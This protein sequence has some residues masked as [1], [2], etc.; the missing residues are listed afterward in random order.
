MIRRA[1]RVAL[2]TPALFALFLVVLDDR[3]AASFATFGSFALLAMVDFGGPLRRRFRGYVVVTAV[4]ALLVAAGTALSHTVLGAAVGMAVVATG[5]SALA[6]LGGYYAA[7]VPALVLPFL[8]A[9][10]APAPAGSS[11]SRLLG[12]CVAGLVAAAAA[13]VLWPVQ[14][15]R[16]LAEAMATALDDVAAL[17]DGAAVDEA[18]V[19]RLDAAA[20]NAVEDATEQFWTSSLRPSGPSAHDRAFVLLLGE[21]RWI[22]ELTRLVLGNRSRAS[23]DDG[24]LTVCTGS[25]RASA[26]A[27]RG[28]PPADLAA[29]EDHRAADLAEVTRSSMHDLAR[30]V[31]PVEVVAQL[32]RSFGVRV[33]S[34]AVLAVAA[35]V[36]LA[37][38]AVVDRPRPSVVPPAPAIGWTGSAQRLHVVLASQLR[39]DGV[40]LRSALR[41]GVALGVA[42]AV[43][44]AGDLPNSFWVGLGAL[45][46][47][48]SNALGTGYTVLQ[49]LAGT[50]LGFALA[51]GLVH[52]A[53]SRW[54]L[55]AL[56][57]VT[58]F[59]AA[60]TPTAVHFLV[61]QASFTVLVV[62]L[63]NLLEPVGWKVGL[64]R[65]QDVAIGLV[66]SLVAS[67]VLWPRG[68]S[69]ALVSSATTSLAA[70][71]RY[72]A[73]A[74]ARWLG[75]EVSLAG[76]RDAAMSGVLAARA[77]FGVY[78]GE[79]GRRRVA[80]EVAAA[81]VGT[82]S[83]AHL[84]AEAVDDIAAG[85]T[86]PPAC[87]DVADRL[88][89][90]AGDL[91]ACWAT[92][93]T[94]DP[95]LD[96]EHLEASAR[97]DQALLAACLARRAGDDVAT[98]RLA[99]VD[100]WLRLLWELARRTEDAAASASR[101][102][103]RPWWA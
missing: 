23:G 67:L 65:L 87:A 71:G 26:A 16:R 50:V 7:A 98:L 27:L 56:L 30:G 18:A 69:R 68:A 29:L 32:R 102:M 55:W 94:G 5:V 54:V 73:D 8:L 70:S 44:Q 35:N 85:A 93:G 88:I 34:Y 9:V 84:A 78:L 40:W 92:L 11:P 21:L 15:R 91:A 95:R 3:N 103:E 81:L 19:A 24:L 79:R 60:Y 89:S 6:V 38:G 47:L 83:V 36:D 22:L 43:A 77:T 99:W 42:V 25:V 1:L 100:G 37:R 58:V 57:P 49:A 20:G 72:F 52:V 101:A 61:G 48:R 41:V 2:V 62:V 10:A 76:P 14:E 63:F 96:T 13:V 28:G 82:G 51:V 75:R 64:V 31:D 12:W 17:V 53:S 66:V 46:A 4:G 97:D 74:V 39:P 33:L 45:T 59:L 90:E 80:P 86:G